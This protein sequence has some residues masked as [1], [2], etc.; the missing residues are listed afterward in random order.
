M[1]TTLL[2]IPGMIH[3]E[4]DNDTDNVVITIPKDA[5][6]SGMHSVLFNK[7][8]IQGLVHLIMETADAQS[9]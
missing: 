1:R 4:M 7:N 9:K 5:A 8:Y 6:I 2:Q 3:V